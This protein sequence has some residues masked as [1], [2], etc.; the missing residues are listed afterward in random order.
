MFQDEVAPP[1]A[2]E[3]RE[4][5]Q[6]SPSARLY[7]LFL[8]IVCVVVAIELFRA[9]RLAPPFGLSRQRN[10]PS[11]LKGLET[12]RTRI[13]QWIL[14]SFLVL[15]IHTSLS[16]LRVCSLLLGESSI[17]A[18]SFL[19][20]FREYA[21]ELMMGLSVAFFG[22]LIQWHFLLRIKRLRE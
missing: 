4:P 5:P 15:G 11:Y 8:L 14:R 19:L 3:L 18:V 7:L 16:L 10:N 20:A 21:A 17:S 22:F 1:Q 2:W 9:W 6:L 12:A 13:T